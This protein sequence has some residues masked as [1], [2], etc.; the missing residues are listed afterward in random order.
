M[1]G[2]SS[3]VIIKSAVRDL[4]D[5]PSFGEAAARLGRIIEAAPGA[6]GAADVL[7]R[8]ARDRNH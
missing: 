7:E 8:L 5:R 4:L 6:A 3:P 1:D 2:E